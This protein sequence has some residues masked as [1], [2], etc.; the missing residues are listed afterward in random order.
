MEELTIF[1]RKGHTSSML[2]PCWPKSII[3]TNLTTW[4]AAGK[5]RGVPGIFDNSYC[6]CHTT[7]FEFYHLKARKYM[8]LK[9]YVIHVCASYTS[10]GIKT[11]SIWIII[12]IILYSLSIIIMAACRKSPSQIAFLGTPRECLLGI[13]DKRNQI[14][15][16]AAFSFFSPFGQC[17]LLHSL[18]LSP[19]VHLSVMS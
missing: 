9:R 8:A 11:R 1:V 4:K 13:W 19:E 17:P 16:G 14:L 5:C 12:N 6:H 2:T 10:L 7:L 15:Q 18:P 3:A